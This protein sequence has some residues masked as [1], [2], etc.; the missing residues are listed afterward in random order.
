M[1]EDL[2]IGR[3]IQQKLNEQERSGAWLARKLFT[4]PSNVSKI[5]H[6]KHLDTALL[7]RISLILNVDFFKYLSES[8]LYNQNNISIQSTF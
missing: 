8:Y 3:L 1:H 6:R 5:I 2:H 7:M 4:D